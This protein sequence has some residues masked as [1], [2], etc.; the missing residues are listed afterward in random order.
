MDWPDWTIS[1]GLLTGFAGA[2]LTV[3]EVARR[4]WQAGEQPQPRSARYIEGIAVLLSQALVLG[5]M[6]LIQ[7]GNL[8]GHISNNTRPAH[9]WLSFISGAGIVLL[10]GFALGRLAMRWQVQRLLDGSSLNA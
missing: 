9:L 10:F 5:G 2:A 7:F 4:L 6:A 1:A 8:A 3:R